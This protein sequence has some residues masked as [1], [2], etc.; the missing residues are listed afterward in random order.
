MTSYRGKKVILY[1]SPIT[2]NCPGVVQLR[3][4]A[5]RPPTA[6]A[7]PRLHQVV[8]RGRA[9]LAAT[10]LAG[11]IPVQDLTAQVNLPEQNP[12]DL[13]LFLVINR[14]KRPNNTRRPPESGT[15]HRLSTRT[16]SHVLQQPLQPGAPGR[17][18][19]RL[20]PALRPASE[21]RLLVS[22][23]VPLTPVSASTGLHQSAVKLFAA[24]TTGASRCGEL[25]DDGAR[26]Q[27]TRHGTTGATRDAA[28]RPAGWSAVLLPGP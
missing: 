25:M 26:R 23:P 24:T 5:K 18:W 22:H 6:G 8:G 12:P 21:C 14:Q 4:G 20:Q 28:V 9:S 16:S 11:P 19:L 7:K 13:F 27:L 2:S 3:T 17:G 10:R 1:R 15:T